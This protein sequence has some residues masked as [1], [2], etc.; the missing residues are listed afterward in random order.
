MKTIKPALLAAAMLLTAALNSCRKDATP[1]P[2]SGI[3]RDSLSMG[4]LALRHFRCNDPKKTLSEGL[5]AYYPF[6]DSADDWSGNAYNG[7]VNGA[8][9]TTGKSGCPNSAYSFNG[10]SDYITL[11]FLYGSD[12]TQFSIYV[13]VKRGANGT[14]YS[15]GQMV[16]QNLVI[17]SVSSDSTSMNINVLLQRSVPNIAHVTRE[18]ANGTLML[19]QQNRWEDIVVTLNY[20]LLQ[21][22]INGKLVISTS[23]GYSFL[24]PAFFGPMTGA[25][26]FYGG[27]S[28]LLT[29]VID[30]MRFYKR[31]LSQREI[32]YLYKH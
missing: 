13:R 15:K 14:I 21:A 19:G 1:A 5:L 22:Y 8:T 6:S 11:P 27:P 31:P 23:M 16:R 29:G 2:V 25:F 12:T 3:H 9:L 10:I 28:G 32:D 17:I 24:F 30:D 20:P 26:M 4:V 18:L 7:E